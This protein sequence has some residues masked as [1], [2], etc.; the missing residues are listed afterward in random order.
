MAVGAE[1]VLVEVEAVDVKDHRFAAVGAGVFDGT[2][3]FVVLVVV[4][5]VVFVVVIVRPVVA[6][7]GLF[8]VAQILVD[9]LDVLVELVQALV[10][11]VVV[12]GKGVQQLQHLADQGAFGLAVVQLEP[13]RQPAQ[14]GY[15]VS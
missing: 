12:L 1:I 11:G 10:Q 5:L 3:V 13:L 2:V 9:A 6:V 7:D 15:A 8:H 14:I 4:I